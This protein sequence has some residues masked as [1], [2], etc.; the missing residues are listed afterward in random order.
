MK[1]VLAIIQIL[2]VL[3]LIVKCVLCLTNLFY[4]L[5]LPIV[6][7]KSILL[8][9]LGKM[10]ALLTS[11][12]K[13]SGRSTSIYMFLNPELHC[14]TCSFPQYLTLICIGNKNYI[15]KCSKTNV[16]LDSNVIAGLQHCFS[17]MHIPL[18]LH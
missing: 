10:D 16:W 7:F 11:H 18:E 2:R 3:F 8:Q 17:I 15:N 4:I 13:F 9:R 5:R 1:L 12:S 6:L 14:V